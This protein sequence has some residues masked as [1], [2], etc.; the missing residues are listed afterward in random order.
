MIRIRIRLLKREMSYKVY[1]RFS[2]IADLGMR[3][4]SSSAC[5]NSVLLVPRWPLV[6]IR[7]V[8]RMENLT[9]R[10]KY[11]IACCREYFSF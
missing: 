7:V 8:R 10:L 5:W 3:F 1:I 9:L 4:R 2:Y 11:E 6:A